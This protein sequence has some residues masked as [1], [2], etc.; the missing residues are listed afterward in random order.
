MGVIPSNLFF[1]ITLAAPYLVHCG[2]QEKKLGPW[3]GSSCY[4]P[5]KGAHTRLAESASI[6]EVGLAGLSDD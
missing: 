5:G 2:C 6:L 1:P 3:L 4:S